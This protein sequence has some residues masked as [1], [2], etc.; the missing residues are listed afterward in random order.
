MCVFS[1]PFQGNAISSRHNDIIRSIVT[2][3]RSKQEALSA[4]RRRRLV[5]RLSDALW[6]RTA[7]AAKPVRQPLA[8]APVVQEH[9]LALLN[10]PISA[11]L[12]GR[13]PA[14]LP[15]RVILARVVEH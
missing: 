13:R 7:H 8:R 11:D 15:A 14:V 12:D 2:R 6:A 1:L 10:V 3:R 5:R 9:L 4:I